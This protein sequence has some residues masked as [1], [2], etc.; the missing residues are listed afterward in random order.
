ME[1]QVYF[2]DEKLKEVYDSL[3]ESKTEEQELHKWISRAI[4]DLKQDAFSGIQIKKEFIPKE[5]IQKYAIDNLWKY[6]LPKGW[7]L[8]YSV[9]RDGIIVL[10]IILEWMDHKNY[11]RRFGY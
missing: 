5:Y 11:E 9:S 8:L 6:D 7:R 4:D 10:S 2:A 3:E 1:S